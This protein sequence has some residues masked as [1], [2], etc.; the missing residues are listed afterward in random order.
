[1]S[2]QSFPKKIELIQSKDGSHT[3]RLPDMNETY[4][5]IHGALNESRHVFISK[6]VSQVNKQEITVFEVGFGTGLNLMTTLEYLVQN[7]GISIN[8]I[9]IEAFPLGNELISKIN[10]NNLFEFD[11]ASTLYQ[12]AHLINWEKPYTLTPQLNLLKLH[13]DFTQIDLSK[14]KVDCIY[15]DAFAPNKQEEMWDIEVLKKCYDMLTEQG[16][17]VTYCAKGQLKRDL[18]SIG[19]E[20]KMKPGPPGKRE[21]TTAIKQK[22]EA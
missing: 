11:D 1:M 3:L 5:S 7:P 18:K 2:E 17:F 12:K 10:Y 4:H 20:L 6:G 16:R 9:T 15:F 19:F 21:M 14:Y 8:Y 13:G 22:R